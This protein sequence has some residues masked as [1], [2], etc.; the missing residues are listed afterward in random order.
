MDTSND[1]MSFHDKA[2]QLHYI[3]RHSNDPNNNFQ[4][5]NINSHPQNKDLY[6][7]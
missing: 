2:N 6:N 5:F 7:E 3:N 4:S 1:G